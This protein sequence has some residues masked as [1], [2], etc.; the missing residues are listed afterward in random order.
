MVI[1]LTTEI[2]K[3]IALLIM[4][5]FLMFV[6]AEGVLRFMGFAGEIFERDAKTGL[7]TLI[8]NWEGYFRKECIQNLVR[9]NSSG[10]HDS[11][12]KIE[13]NDNV[14]RIAI[15]GD[16]YV[17]ALQVPL[18]KTFH[19]L[20]EKKLNA[21]MGSRKKFEVYAFGHSGNGTFLNY[22]YLKKHA[23]QYKP[24]LVIDAFLIGNDFRDDSIELSQKDGL[25]V[26]KMFPKM[27]EKGE[28]DSKNADDFL[29]DKT[30]SNA[31]MF[32]KKIA[33]KSAFVMWLY[34]KYHMTKT[35]LFSKKNEVNLSESFKDPL[36]VILPYD[37]VFLKEYPDI[38]KNVWDMEEKLLSEMKKT[39][40]KNGAEFILVS[41]TEGFR[42]Y[43]DLMEEKNFPKEFKD[44][45]DFDKPE[46][47]LK[48]ISE[49]NNFYYLPLLLD[50]KERA[51]DSTD[52][53]VFPCDGHWNETGHLWAAEEIFKYLESVHLISES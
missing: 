39:A 5:V 43:P 49:R 23:L 30:K 40:E 13:K 42:L 48:E 45:L 3:K 10:F 15:V 7:M 19:Y 34:P 28:L 36:D 21:E 17:E 2:I 24:D 50:F 9:T 47:L 26:P 4:S 29:D 8:P 27:D 44:K 6:V 32:L 12:F 35:R 46:R 37:Q 51:K 16:S 25:S 41:L 22:L 38:F 53:T 1:K 52:L 18:E 20:L 11:E 31:K 14:Y 33:S